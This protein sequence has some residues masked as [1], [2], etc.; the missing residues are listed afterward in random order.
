[1]CG[2]SEI[3]WAMTRRAMIV[4]SSPSWLAVCSRTRERSST[5]SST[6]SSKAAVATGSMIGSAGSTS[7]WAIA[8]G[9][10]DGMRGGISDARGGR[11]TR[12]GSSSWLT[13]STN[14][15]GKG[16]GRR[17]GSSSFFTARPRADGS[18]EGA[19]T[20][21]LI[22]VAKVTL[23]GPSAMG[24]TSPFR[25]ASNHR[26]LR[27]EGNGALCIQAQRHF[28]DLALR[29]FDIRQANAAHHFHIFLDALCGA[30]AHA[31]KDVIS[32]RFRG[33]L[34]RHRQLLHGHGLE[35]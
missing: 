31:G 10:L 18:Q 19:R 26:T 25:P 15:L 34:H 29:A 12:S 11:E 9:G 2:F 27:L 16:G 23:R 30:L 1:M 13:A 20:R 14:S 3:S 24:S 33:G 17:L 8:V 35:Q 6:A 28:D 5:S 7:A 4:A 32:E 21:G 22:T